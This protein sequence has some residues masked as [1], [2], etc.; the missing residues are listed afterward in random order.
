MTDTQQIS[1]KNN[2]DF[3]MMYNFEYL[4]MKYLRLN[5]N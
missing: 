5:L 1:K 2:D 4:R 3:K